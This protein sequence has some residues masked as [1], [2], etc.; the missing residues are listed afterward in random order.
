MQT[1]LNYLFL[2]PFLLNLLPFDV[3]KAEFAQLFGLRA[4]LIL[5]Q[6][7]KQFVDKF[8]LSTLLLKLMVITVLDD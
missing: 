4:I 1:L 6:N 7:A 5:R 8:G 3:F 2:L